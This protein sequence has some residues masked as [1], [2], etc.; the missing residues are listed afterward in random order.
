MTTKDGYD[1]EVHIRCGR[2]HGGGDDKCH[3]LHK[4]QYDEWKRRKAEEE[5]DLETPIPAVRA[6]TSSVRFQSGIHG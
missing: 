3:N 5:P 4:D 6:S 2:K 1:G